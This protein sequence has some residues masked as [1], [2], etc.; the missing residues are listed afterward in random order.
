MWNVKIKLL[1]R[2]H[3]HAHT[4]HLTR[5][6][7]RV[8]RGFDFVHAENRLRVPERISDGQRAALSWEQAYRDTARTLRE[9]VEKHG[10][11]SLACGISA[12]DST[13]DTFLLIKFV[14]SIDP[15]AWLVLPSVRI[16]GRDQVFKNPTTGA[17]TFILRAE[18]APNR[19]GAEKI[20][21]H[22]GGNTCT[23][24]EL[25]NKKIAAAVR[26]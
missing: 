12:F 1:A 10:P 13:E 15:Q 6:Q 9:A 20:I 26:K 25:A 21:A 17:I 23:L 2:E 16:E 19:R 7:V 22:F 4:K 5:A 11:G 3:A 24:A 18:K 8:P 14:R